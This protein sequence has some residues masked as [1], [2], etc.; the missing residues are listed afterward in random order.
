MGTI[1]KPHGIKG[2]LCV[3]W[4][5][6]SIELLRKIIYLQDNGYEPKLV[7]SISVRMHKKQPL[8]F[9]EHIK[10]RNDAEKVRGLKIFVHTNDLPKLDKDEVYLHSLLGL[11]IVL[12]TTNEHIGILQHIEYPAG[13][14][15]W[16]ILTESKQEILFPAV[17]EFIVA[18]KPKEEQIIISPPDG[19]LEICISD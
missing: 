14:E 9:L 13:Q 2:E 11:N 17:S 12:E 18:I 5:S 1:T 6:Q 19:L 8:L 3:N 16:V 4:F 7:K 15:M 10:D